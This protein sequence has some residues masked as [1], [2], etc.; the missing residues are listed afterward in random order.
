[1]LPSVNE[2]SDDTVCER[3]KA[4]LQAFLVRDSDLLDRDASER[5]IAHKFAEHLQWMFPEWQVDCEYNRRGRSPKTHPAKPDSKVFPDIII[6]RR[7]GGNLIVFEIK[8]SNNRSG[9]RDDLRKLKGFTGRPD[10][11]PLGLFLVFDVDRKCVCGVKCFREGRG[12]RCPADWASLTT[13]RG[14]ADSD[15]WRSHTGLGN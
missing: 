11:Y 7:G 3:V 12:G 15:G 10:H 14:H 1:M 9:I 6:H 2:L 8:K 13:I 4:A 5:S